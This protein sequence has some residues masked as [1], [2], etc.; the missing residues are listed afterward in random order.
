MDKK[1]IEQFQPEKEVVLTWDDPSLGIRTQRV[2]YHGDVA[3]VRKHP[4]IKNVFNDSGRPSESFS[5]LVYSKD[6][7]IFTVPLDRIIQMLPGR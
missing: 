5:N 3:H 2:L 4:L 1:D 6:D 7:E